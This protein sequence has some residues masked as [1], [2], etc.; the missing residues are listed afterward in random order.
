MSELLALLGSLG[1]QVLQKSEGPVE[2]TLCFSVVPLAV[3]M[4]FFGLRARR[5]KASAAAH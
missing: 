2:E 5:W 1:A 4:V 3:A